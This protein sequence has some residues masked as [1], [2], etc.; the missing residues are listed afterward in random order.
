MTFRVFRDF[1]TLSVEYGNSNIIFK[2][3]FVLCRLNGLRWWVKAVCFSQWETNLGFLKK[4]CC[5]GQMTRCCHSDEFLS[6]WLVGLNALFCHTERKWSIHK[7][8]V[9][10][11]T[12]KAWI[13]RFLSK[14]QN[15]KG[16]GIFVF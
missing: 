11:Y 6:Y 7:F 14:A 3:F 16:F 2:C 5:V 8:K 15:D 9:R 12:F 13:F 10:I 4:C 1:K